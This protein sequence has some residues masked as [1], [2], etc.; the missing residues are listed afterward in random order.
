M[1]KDI[2]CSNLCGSNKLQ[3]P[4]GNVNGGKDRVNV[5]Y[6]N[7]RTYIGSKSHRF[8][9]PESTWI[10]L[11]NLMLSEENQGTEK[12]IILPAMKVKPCQAKLL[13]LFVYILIYI[14]P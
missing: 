8:E 12:S 3:Q 4:K 5:I 10:N 2:H 9:L 11:K 7:V 13:F 6:A 14:Q 1:Y